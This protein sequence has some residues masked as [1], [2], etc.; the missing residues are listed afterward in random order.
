MPQ[1]LPKSRLL[2][3]LANPPVSSGLRTTR[4][5]ELAR[6][7]LQFDDV[8]I[9]NLFAIASLSSNDITTLGADGDAWLSARGTLATEVAASSA[10]LLAYGTTEPAGSAR[11]HHRAQLDWL[12]QTL[13]SH[14]VPVLQFGGAPRHPSRWHRWTA[15]NYPGV[16]FAKIFTN[17]FAEAPSPSSQTPTP[18][19]AG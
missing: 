7:A 16:P 12:W 6:G 3:V 4:R 9:A 5:V 10:V 13:T 2:C 15:Q 1:K 18:A 19:L 17:G 11:I 14:Q 8:A